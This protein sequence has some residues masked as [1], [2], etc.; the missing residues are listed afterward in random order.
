MLAPTLAT[1]DNVAYETHAYTLV[2]VAGA[3]AASF[4]INAATGSVTIKGAVSYEDA[5]LG[6]A[7]TVRLTV[8]SAQEVGR[9]AIEQV[10]TI[11]INDVNEA[12]TAIALS[13]L[14]LAENEPA[15][16]IIGT[17]STT[18]PDNALTTDP[19][20]QTFTYAITSGSDTTFQIQGDRLMSSG[21]LDFE[22]PNGPATHTYSL[23]IRSTDSAT[24]ALSVESTFTVTLTDV[25]EAPTVSF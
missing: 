17:L 14:T 24:D 18:D 21:P 4:E 2:S 1:D 15:G 16:T 12:P 13:A 9:L 5:A 22:D 11:A 6:D 19:T 8:R 23:T 20:R 10:M 3:D 7:K 25:N